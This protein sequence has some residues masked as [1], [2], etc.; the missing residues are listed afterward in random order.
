MVTMRF[1]TIVFCFVSLCALAAPIAAQNLNQPQFLPDSEAK[2]ER[3]PDTSSYI[4]RDPAPS[5]YDLTLADA[6]SR[7]L[8]NSVI[9]EL[10][11]TQIAAKCYTMQAAEKD[12]LLKLLNAFRYF[13]FESDLQLSFDAGVSV[14]D[15]TKC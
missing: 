7:V 6:K 9:M 8:E 11:S 12:Y 2:V 5:T 14:Y 1:S 13:H 15:Q 10:A 4:S 3:L